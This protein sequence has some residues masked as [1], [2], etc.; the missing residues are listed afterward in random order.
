MERKHILPE[1][2]DSPP[3]YT[4]AVLTAGRPLLVVSGQVSFTPAGELVGRHDFAAQV[5]QCFDNLA[6]VLA[7]GG[8]AFADVVKLTYFVVGL[9]KER[10]Q[11]VRDVR[12]RYLA[13]ER[14]PASSLFGV[15]ALFSEE[16]LIEIEA[17]A[18][19]PAGGR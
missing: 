3:G 11:V 6:V 12:D 2:W 1:G 9:T 19:L 16:A 10:L 4:P 5:A 13:A 15:V 14:R 17:L 7:A 18:E 8:C